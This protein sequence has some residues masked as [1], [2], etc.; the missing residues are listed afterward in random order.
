MYVILSVVTHYSY[1]NQVK[2]FSSSCSKGKQS[3]QFKTQSM[4]YQFDDFSRR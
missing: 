4:F 2:D 3:I 1:I